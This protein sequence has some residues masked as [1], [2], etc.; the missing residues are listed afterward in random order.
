MNLPEDVYAHVAA[1][2][3][4]APNALEV[5]VL[6]AMAS[7]HCSYAS[8]R[9][10]LRTL[11]REGARVRVGPGENAGV[12]DIGHGRVAV[13]K[14]ES[15]N[16]PSALAPFAGAATGVG[17]I[18]RDVVAM[19]ARPVAFLDSLRFG[20]RHDPRVR[21]RLTGV[22][23]GI[24]AYANC[25][26]VPTVGG[27]LRF[28]GSYDDNCL[29]NVFCCGVARSEDVVRATAGAPGNLVVVLGNRT[30]RDGVGGAVM[31]S[32]AFQGGDA[33][34]AAH[35]ALQ[36]GDPF[37]GKLLL[38]A[39][40]E[41]AERH[42]VAGVQDM[43]AAGLV[44]S[45]TE[46]AARAGC[47]MVLAVDR[48]PR[49]DAS[50]DARE[51]L[52]SESQERMLLAVRPADV[53]AVRAVAAR[54]HLAAAVV[55]HVTDDGVWRATWEGVE[56]A[57][58]PSALAAN[59]APER[60]PP[61]AR[62]TPPA[63][64]GVRAPPDAWTPVVLR[65]LADP[66]AC[67]RGW[68]WRQY[69]HQVGVDTVRGPGDDAACVRVRGTPVTLAFACD[70]NAR[71]VRVDPRLGTAGQ[72]AEC[73]RNLACVGATPVGLTNCLNFGRPTDP[74]VAGQLAEAVAGLAEACRA[75]GVPVVS[76]NVSLSNTTGT[77]SVA[78]TPIVAAVG[79]LEG[80][81][82]VSG[83]LPHAGLTV[84]LLGHG[85]ARPTDP[86]VLGGSLYL[87]VTTGD[88]ARGCLPPLDLVAEQALHDALRRL[89][90]SEL[91]ATAHDISD[92]GLLVALA[93]LGLPAHAEAPPVGG[94]Y[95]VP[96][97]HPVALVGEAHGRA[98][99]AFAPSVEPEVRAALG[100]VPMR[101]LGVSGGSELHV[102]G[103]HGEVLVACAASTVVD[104]WTRTL[105]EWLDP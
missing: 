61:R 14:M 49:R 94:H 16:H 70:G 55:G 8:S 67:D 13:F 3:G 17:G 29:V 30:G 88:S 21:P 38:E 56:V 22:V 11:P 77:R 63:P 40:L 96:D 92:G 27:E 50:M 97:I 89:I 82:R 100:D 25:V 23:A 64:V 47:G 62:P 54:W 85:T 103:P 69:D 7:E 104:A 20:T 66:D 43:G 57:A 102:R 81:P 58:L 48:V 101:V 34:T 19:G 83:R 26:G 44:S 91:L 39:T 32:G 93:E 10:L 71:H 90:A 95:T 52:L 74:V 41:L 4:R 86:E 46:M 51:V 15:H 24:S 36:H 53:D 80:A 33:D 65:M 72:V 75:F 1:T 98:L 45:S 84:A 28:D 79:V 73:L 6:A 9:A 87:H 76:G 12:V 18:L 78:P 37:L 35:A 42:L 2:L 105:P 99:I 60:H 59:P 5:E 31:A 68:V